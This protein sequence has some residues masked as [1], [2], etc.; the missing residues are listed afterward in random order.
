M[1]ITIDTKTDSKE[2]IQKAID[3][4]RS[5]LDQSSYGSYQPTSYSTGANQVNTAPLLDMFNSPSSASTS[6]P[7]AKVSEGTPPDFTSF[8]NLGQKEDK[9]QQGTMG[10]IELY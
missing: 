9:K 6:I 10:K 3:L 4:L 8:L 5:L 1:I 7:S 2:E